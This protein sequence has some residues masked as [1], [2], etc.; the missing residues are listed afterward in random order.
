MYKDNKLIEYNVKDIFEKVA[1][2]K[3]D[4][5]NDIMSFGVHRLWKKYYVKLLEE[6]HK[7]NEKI[8]NNEEQIYKNQSNDITDH[9]KLIDLLFDV[10][11]LFLLT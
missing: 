11:V 1:S 8:L 5:M 3:Y 9:L 2:E 7:P 10:F 6:L 4:L